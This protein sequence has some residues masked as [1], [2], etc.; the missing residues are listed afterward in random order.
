MGRTF[1]SRA[2]QDTPVVSRDGVVLS[3]N[4]RTMAGELAARD[5][6]DGAYLDHLTRFGR[7]YGFTPEQVSSMQHPRLVFVADEDMPYT[8]ETF[9]KF[10]AQQMKSQDRTETAVK[11]GKTVPDNTFGRIV[12]DINRFDTLSQFYNDPKASVEA[13]NDLR[14]SGVINP[15]QYAEMFDGKKV[16]VIGRQMLENMLL[17]K[18]FESNPDALREL[19]KYP[20]LRQSVVAALA[21]ISN[22]KRLGDYSLE[23]EL[24]EAI[25]LAYTALEKGRKQGDVVSDIA[26]QLNLF[27]FDLGR[28]SVVDYT[29]ASILMLADVLNSTEV[30]KLRNVLALYNDRAGNASNGNLTLDF[31]ADEAG[32][33][34]VESKSQIIKDV[35][36]LIENGDRKE[37]QRAID[38]ARER[39]K[40]A[41]EAEQGDSGT[42]QDGTVERSDS[43]SA[44]AERSGGSEKETPSLTHNEAISLIAEMEER[45]EL[46]PDIELTIENWDALFGEEGRVL[47]PI[48]EVKMG[49]NQFTKLMR[50]GR[51]GKLGM[52]KPTL[53]NPDVIIED[54]SEAKDGETT[55]RKSSY[56]FVKAF[57]KADGSR[58]YY[59]TS[60]TV[61][62]DGKEV[63]I[64]NQEKRK[65]AI[66]NLLTKGKLVWKHADDVSAASDVE[67]GLYSSQ[68]NMSDPTT[69]G[70]DAPQTNDVSEVFTRP[71][72]EPDTNTDTSG[73]D[74]GRSE[75]VTTPAGNSPRTSEDKG[76][77]N[78]ET[79][80][81]KTEKVAES[82]A[83]T[84]IAEAEQE[85][86]TEPTDAQKEA[87]NYKK[88]HIKLD[89]FDISIEQPKGSTRSGRDASGKE[90]SVTMQNTYG[91]IRGTE[92]VD[93]DHIDVFLSDNMD[94]WNGTV[95][96]IDQVKADGSFDEHKVMYGF[97]SAEEA[98]AAYN[99]NY[100]EGWQGLGTI[101]GVSKE[102]FKKWIGS[103]HRKTKPFADYKKVKTDEGQ[104]KPFV[105]EDTEETPT[106]LDEMRAAH[107]DA[108]FLVRGQKLY[109]AYGEDAKKLGEILGVEVK[110]DK[111]YGFVASFDHNDLDTNLPKLV[112]AGLRVAITDT[113][114]LKGDKPASRSKKT[115][116]EQETSPTNRESNNESSAGVQQGAEASDSSLSD[117]Q[118]A[119]YT[120]EPAQYTTKRGKVLDMHLVKFGR[121]LTKDEKQALTKFA[122]DNKGWW[123][124]EKGGFMMRDEATAK[125]L[126]DMLGDEEAVK[127]NQP[128][129]LADVQA[130]NDAAA[131]QAVDEAIKVEE[132]PQS[133]PQ[134]DYD[135]EDEVYDQVL[136][137]L[138]ET[139]NNAN[140]NAIPN[141]KAIEKK[142]R[143]LRKSIT[144]VDNGLA[145]AGEDTI[146]KAYETLATLTGRMKAYEKFLAELRK[147]MSE[148]ERDN[149]L[150][151]RGVKLGD[152]VTYK[153]K[154]ATIHDADARQVTLDVGLSPVLYEVTD[155]ENVELPKQEPTTP[156][157]QEV[158]VESLM[159]ELGRKGEAS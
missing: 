78:S 89:G 107:P 26:R 90:W 134:Y 22:N 119:N 86:N 105:S 146:G 13:I 120:V 83:S 112:R 123:D 64:S 113:S 60:V 33:G 52:I 156:Q 118:S 87:G 94:E 97:N 150:A 129:S 39:R 42:E 154:P 16:S 88:G 66:A 35:L 41:A 76:S 116:N 8:T 135:R 137:G 18:A 91:Y 85:V 115:E 82:K 80:K 149:A 37:K 81:E 10:N 4:G 9:A 140:G 144:N 130:V 21:E 104:S 61:S 36:N 152:K 125:Q 95:Y 2:I 110:P 15:M 72:L 51:E 1:D 151:A 159:G 50:Q 49:E 70:T 148:T 54:A 138:R 43:G 56:V 96:V 108:L 48:G 117:G 99:S 30:N 155:W 74:S 55:E 31:D 20:Q 136:A 98:A 158:N 46:A 59:F 103:S 28:G 17:G 111:K 47:T 14:R 57:K 75:G 157:V 32:S 100:S 53:E 126:G 93:G 142:I 34:F 153:G 27:P 3:G 131:V 73:V 121:E 139:L 67:Q 145:T 127:D 114:V 122:K 40:D 7:Q 147:K 24:S 11:L 128:M 132:K 101:T 79:G 12:G 102:E 44:G 84:A 58:Y 143:E 29:N 65:N 77:E 109:K 62:K 5:N 45:A 133:T 141:I 71:A 92:G 69:E 106:N 23:H 19:A 25:H 124:R 63:V 38:E 6:T 68:G